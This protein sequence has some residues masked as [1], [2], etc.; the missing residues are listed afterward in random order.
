MTTGDLSDGRLS[1]KV[2]IITGGASGIGRATVIRFLEEGANVVFGD[3]NLG[4]GSALAED[5][6]GE[7]GPDRVRF[8][9]CDVSEE[10]DI[11]RL[12]EFTR[13][14]FGRLD[15]FVNNA[16]TGGALTPLIDTTV[17]DWDRSQQI[18]LRSVFL[19]IKHAAKAFIAQGTG[20]AIINIGSLAGATGGSAGAAYSTAK[21][22]VLNLTRVAASQLGKYQIRVNTVTPG[23]IATPLTLRGNDSTSFREAALPTQPLQ[24]VGEP[25]HVAPAIA[26]LCS[27]D[28]SFITGDNLVVD[29]GVSAAGGNIYSGHHPLG[30]AI[31]ENIRKSGATGMDLGSTAF[32]RIDGRFPVRAE[33][34]L[35]PTQRDTRRTVAI[36]GVSRG[37]GLALTRKLIELGHTVLGCARSADR[38][39]E[40][41][42]EFGAPHR[43]DVV[44]VSDEESIKNWV[45]AL[46]ADHREPDLV[47]CNAALTHAGLQLWRFETEEIERV[48][49]TNLMGTTHIARQFI[50]VMLRLRRGVIVNFSSGWGRGVSERAAPY[51]ASKWG[52][53]GLTRAFAKELPPF[54]AAV[55][56][57][58]GIIHTETMG[59]TFGEAADLYPNPQE[60]AEIAAPFILGIS[61]RD[62]GAALT[63]P[64]MS[65][66]RGIG[67]AATK[68]RQAAEHTRKK[69]APVPSTAQ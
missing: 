17:E 24:E 35:T 54:M 10:S 56:L 69:D 16:G 19:G 49:R 61:P 45:R 63:V 52:V 36:T 25:H 34:F 22:G 47:I 12:V 21:G 23:T 33:Q 65:A 11:I 37:L 7:V 43:F 39:E 58:P 20:G 44:D 18:L 2:A 9:P 27:D 53:E 29:G 67:N 50:P 51:C 60:W 66:F 55:T 48:I 32:S 46:E 14:T 26:F 28:S 5:L 42:Q 3:L 1:G 8:F 57:H 13:T 59:Q 4:G 64:G 38:V 62:N 15:A 31:S 68:E 30:N 40:L 6:A 41:N